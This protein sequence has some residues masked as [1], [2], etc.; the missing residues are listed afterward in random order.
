M[1]NTGAPTNSFMSGVGTP[2]GAGAGANPWANFFHSFGGGGAGGA[3]GAGG[4]G[5]GFDPYMHAGGTAIAQYLKSIQGMQDPTGYM[6]HIM[7]QYSQSPSAKLQTT[8]AIGA[9]NQ[10]AAQ[11]GMLGAGSTQSAI[12]RQAQ[13]ISQADQQRYL[14]NALGIQ[15]QYLGG[16][17]HISGLGEQ[18]AGGQAQAQAQ[19][20]Q[21]A[22]QQRE[23]D[24]KQHSDAH[25]SL[26]SNIAG[27]LGVAAGTAAHFGFL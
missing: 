10:A 2:P 1:L 22:E 12:A 7:G 26:W 3:G 17:G 18:A 9:A 20:A 15:G 27:G 14:T 4:I 21:L 13:G 24:A 11:S 19:A 6:A 5:S 8:Q 23:F 16:L 25:N